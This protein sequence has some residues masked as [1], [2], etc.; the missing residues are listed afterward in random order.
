[1]QI[2]VLILILLICSYSS[3][4]ADNRMI[5]HI[6]SLIVYAS[7][8]SSSKHL[9][10]VR[11]LD[12]A[13]HLSKKN[14]YKKGEA[15]AIR[16]K[17]LALFYGI[18]YHEAL[19]LFLESKSKFEKI[20][21]LVGVAN[22]NHLIAIVY[23]YHKLHK[24]SLELNIENLALRE[25]L[26]DS[27][28]I[29]GTLNNIGVD[30]KD[31][32]RRDE[33]LLYY[34]RAVEIEVKIKD[35]IALSRYYDNIGSI[36]LDLHQPDS[37]FKYLSKS[38]EMRLIINDRQGIMNSYESF[39]DY[40]YYLNNFR[41]AKD[42]CKK[43]LDLAY[44]IGIVYEIESIS[45]KLGLIYAKL[46]MNLEAYQML[47]LNRKMLDSLK[48]NETA[49]LL[50]SIDVQKAL[51]SEKKIQ[52]LM[53]E[54]NKFEKENLRKSENLLK[55]I[56]IF[57][58]AI[59]L[60]I[61]AF[62]WINLRNKK[63]HNKELMDKQDQIE[64]KNVEIKAQNDAILEQN[65]YLSQLNN[66][67]DKFFSIIAHDLK[68]PFT[69][70]MGLS[71]ELAENYQH[72]SQDDIREYASSLQES[73]VH[74]Y[75]LLEN[76]LEWSR[77]QRGVTQFNPEHCNINYIIQQNINIQTEVSRQKEISLVTN[78]KEEY[79]AYIDI[80][81]INTVIRNLL[82]NSIKFTERGGKIEIAAN[83]NNNEGNKTLRISISDNGIGM[84]S[85]I[86]DNLFKIDK[87]I[88]RPGTENEP[89]TG[90]GLL[91]C[92]EFV[93]KHNGRIWV[94]SEVG[95]GSTFYIELPNNFESFEKNNVLI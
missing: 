59:S 38:L 89:S 11:I 81:M 37:A 9:H 32:N 92:K 83:I 93:E 40:Y 26:G 3:K 16:K 48:E 68:S 56:L 34:K 64:A 41:K 33:A 62:I 77:I 49:E 15:E 18:Q 74:L 19:Q 63:Q 6:D 54:K 20:N 82:S 24:K 10:A 75:K 90:L 84:D 14:N 78:L 8:I 61:I 1:M 2:V 7:S 72:F 87:K 80:P 36:Y 88:S 66:E 53:L 73:A 60:I 47:I 4:A 28:G 27:T 17:G 50:T 94:E 69:G 25:R 86:K 57:T 43:G 12:S 29:S 58:I 51:S 35:S 13:I 21:D 31:L 22:S 70:F 46:G 67:K 5:S 39:G 42:F 23:S 45:Y 65:N 85:F 76:L 55:I 30:L 71:K 44:E 52:Q 95:Q 91:L 79:Y